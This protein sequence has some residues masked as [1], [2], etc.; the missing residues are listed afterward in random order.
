MRISVVV[1][2]EDPLEDNY[3]TDPHACGVEDWLD[4]V[5][6]SVE[7]FDGVLDPFANVTP[8]DRDQSKKDDRNEID[9]ER[10][11]PG[12]NEISSGPE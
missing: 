8:A 4:G 3:P 9:Y 1:E 10:Q 6:D 2:L 7:E 11:P 12:H 5:L